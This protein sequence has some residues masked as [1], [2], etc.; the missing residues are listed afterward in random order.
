MRMIRRASYY[1]LSLLCVL[2]ILAVLSRQNVSLFHGA[3]LP[4]WS[5]WFMSVTGKNA[6][7]FMKDAYELS[8]KNILFFFAGIGL[9]VLCRL[10]PT[11]RNWLVFQAV[12]SHE[13]VHLTV[14]ALFGGEP[15]SLVVSTDDGGAAH[16][17]KSNFIVRLAP[18]IVPLFTTILLGL[19]WFVSEDYRWGTILLAGFFYG[20][21]ILPTFDS[22][23][24]PQPD[25][26]RSG[27]KI[28]ALPVI[29]VLNIIVLVA[30]GHALQ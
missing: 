12:L 22:L 13:L 6:E 15:L 9:Y 10:A 7:S 24:R 26:E 11:L 27:G 20:N 19:S 21:Y 14:A 18:Y 8:N 25:I 17:T 2:I 23:R 5:K 1:F 16:S 30:I 28:I 3:K 4:V 29:L